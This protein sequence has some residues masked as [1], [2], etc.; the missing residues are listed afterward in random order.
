MLIRTPSTLFSGSAPTPIEPGPLMSVSGGKPAASQAAAK[1]AEAGVQTAH[2]ADGHGAIATVVIAVEVEIALEPAVER[3]DFVVGP[4]RC[5]GGDP[6]GKVLGQAAA[7]DRAVQ[8]ARAAD[9]TAAR[10][11]LVD[12]RAQRRIEVP[13]VWVTGHARAE[14]RAVAQLGRIG[15]DAAE[16]GARLDQQDRTARMLGQPRCERAAR[17]ACA[18]HDD[19]IGRRRAIPPGFRPRSQTRSSPR[20]GRGRFLRTHGRLATCG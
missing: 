11:R 20:R 9:D 8:R 2:A 6:V 3:Q 12:A 4:G 5:A 18:D 16:V 19:I 10:Q 7:E 13:I 17:R 15:V 1:A 14:M